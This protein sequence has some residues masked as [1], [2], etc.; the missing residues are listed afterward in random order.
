MKNMNNFQKAIISFLSILAVGIFGMIIWVY[1]TKWTKPL[2]PTLQLALVTP[3]QMPP[4]WTPNPNATSSLL[5]TPQPASI[6]QSSLTPDVTSTDAIGSCG[7]PSVTTIL[8]IGSDTRS[9]KY[10]YGLADV[11]RLILIDTVI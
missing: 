5:S 10:I 3:F 6:I 8:A 4:T 9:Y 11:I 1:Q 2:G 7:M